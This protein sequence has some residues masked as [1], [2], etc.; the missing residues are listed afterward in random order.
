VLTLQNPLQKHKLTIFNQRSN[1]NNNSNN[2]N[3]LGFI[4]IE[5]NIFNFLIIVLLTCLSFCLK[6]DGALGSS[7]CSTDGELQIVFLCMEALA[8]L[9]FLKDRLLIAL[10]GVY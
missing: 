2:N 8:F 10:A 7:V 4:F 6:A 1:N 9:A 5:R 3:A